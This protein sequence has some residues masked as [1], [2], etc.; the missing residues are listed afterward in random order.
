MKYLLLAVTIAGLTIPV[1]W[2]MERDGR[3]DKL[4]MAVQQ[5]LDQQKESAR[6]P[7]GFGAS[8]GRTLLL[9][10]LRGA[11]SQND[12]AQIEAALDG[13]AGI[14][15]SAPLRE[16]CEEISGQLRGE[17]EAR[18]AKMAEEIKAAFRHAEQAVPAARKASDLDDVLRELSRFSDQGGGQPQSAA[19]SN[20]LSKVQ[21][22][23][24][25]VTSWQNYLG[26][27]AAGNV[28][29]ARE[30]LQDL[31]NDKGP[32]YLIPRSEILAR[33]AF[34][35]KPPVEQSD[36]G[37]DQENAVNQNQADLF[38]VAEPLWFNKSARTLCFHLEKLDQLDGVI[39]ALQGL[40]SRTAFQSYGKFIDDVLK[41]LLN[42]NGAY[43][44]YKA[45]LV[46]NIETLSD[47][48]DSTTPQNQLIPLRAELMLLALP[49]YL[50]LP[51]ESK[52]KP[53]ENVYDFLDRI[54]AE[55]LSKSDYLLV[56]RVRSIQHFL[57]DGKPGDSDAS[58][59]AADF[60]MARNQEAAGQY[61]F[62]VASYERA[63]ACGTDLVPPKAIGERLAAI[64][65]EHPDDFKQ[66]V[67]LYFIA[68]PPRFSTIPTDWPPR[69]PG[70]QTF[71]AFLHRFP[72]PTTSATPT[73][74]PSPVKK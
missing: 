6:A 35:I 28:Q 41:S 5:E 66:G 42:L 46:V 4:L 39:D 27:S 18:E 71:P 23:L 63:L 60:V 16:Q 31:L 1:S 54:E 33:F 70:S 26:Y 64:K 45:G 36:R 59:Q 13:L 29:G 57:K 74:S 58:T 20:E 65:A 19:A 69:R 17:R 32:P 7:S 34:M 43:K 30:A 52:A 10:R 61:A 14:I 56:A 67:D 47:D 24:Q 22:V 12:P 9:L 49:R 62:A 25:F 40:K 38:T 3:L 53:G 11:I 73:P 55:G 37:N 51:P 21:P 72:V 2:S 48:L 15:E 68:R 50:G 8:S 44:E